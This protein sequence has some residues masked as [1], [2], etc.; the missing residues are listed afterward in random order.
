MMRRA[1]VFGWS[2]SGLL[3]LAGCSSS[4]GGGGAAAGGTGNVGF[5]GAG[6]SGNQGAGTGIG[7]AP[8]GGAAGASV[9]GTGAQGGS[10][11]V[12]PGATGAPCT[13]ASDC[14]GTNAACLTDSQ[15][16]PNG[17]CSN[18]NCTADSCAA[19][20]ECFE[21]TSGNTYCLKTC[22]QKS[23]CPAA[24]ACHSAGACIPGCTG[25]GDCD[26][27]EVCYK[28]T[29][30]CDVAPCTT[31]SCAAGLKC[32]TGSGKCIP[33]TG[34][35][36]PPGPG[37]DCTGKLPQ[38]DCTGTLSYCGELLPFEPDLGPG[39]EDYPINGE[40]QTNQ[41]RSYLRRDVQMLVKYAAAYVECKASNW[42]TGNGGLIGLGDMSE[43]NGDI[44]GTS[45]GQPGH[46]A[47]THVNGYDID[48]GYF[49]AGTAD[50]KLRPIC[51][52]TSGGQDQYHCTA[53]PDHLDLW[54]TTL[55]LGALMTSEIVRV[56]GVDGQ[57]GPLV[58][59][60]A[61][62]LCSGGYLPQTACNKMGSKLAYETVNQ[63]YGWY[64]FH[65]H[66]MHLSVTGKLPTNPNAIAPDFGL[67]SL[68][69]GQSFG[70]GALAPFATIPGHGM[71]SDGPL[72]VVELPASVS[73]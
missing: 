55:Y 60:A 26:T 51:P 59:Q 48:M 36:P 12:P 66:H 41:Y 3:L 17:Y 63:N 18:S 67:G 42:N 54:R 5:G 45:V 8:M 24:Y 65:H 73:H 30:L 19:G 27:G 50:N 13:Q 23:D 69:A 22:S 33:D 38:R 70:A 9:G 37:P 7:G 71:V 57:V 49:Q 21:M 64:Q 72:P 52:H 56:I 11:S 34:S 53:P 15:G 25:D 1:T 61:P 47:G 10:T 14:S 20:A 44:P 32:D 16:W 62:A 40:T 31:G 28:D 29:G 4:D 6:G 58:E 35:G 68:V 46:P 2:V 43:K 39:Y